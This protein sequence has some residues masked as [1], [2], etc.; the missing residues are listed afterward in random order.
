MNDC[1]CDGPGQ[2]GERKEFS[3]T[4]MMVGVSWYDLKP[5]TPRTRAEIEAELERITQLWAE[6]AK[7]NAQTGD[8]A[9]GCLALTRAGF[10]DGL[11]WVLK[12]GHFRDMS[13]NAINNVS[14]ED[15][16]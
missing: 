13:S 8:S 10:R 9:T 7:E 4:Q 15:T 5:A 14:K 3:Y 6:A 1:R 2:I 12:K 11:M 16:K